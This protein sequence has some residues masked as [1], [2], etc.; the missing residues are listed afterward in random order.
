MENF[1]EIT[2]ERNGDTVL[3]TPAGEIDLAA[4]AELEAVLDSVPDRGAVVLDMSA[5]TFM[6]LTG[7]YFL[8]DLRRV[9]DRRGSTL[10]A[11]GWRRQPLRLLACTVGAGGSAYGSAEATAPVARAAEVRGQLDAR[12]ALARYLG[13]PRTPEPSPGLQEV[14]R[15]SG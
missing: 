12:A 13:A 15:E 14:R 2:V 9:A 11:T 10:T 4:E 3:I 1:F 8:L 7:L 6:D 5:V